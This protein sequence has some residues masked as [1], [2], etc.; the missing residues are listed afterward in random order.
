MKKMM[1]KLLVALLLI[2]LVAA[3][4]WFYLPKK[5]QR[6]HSISSAITVQATKV[7]Q[8]LQSPTLSMIGLLE[9]Q[10]SVMITPLIAGTIRAVK[11]SPG[12]RVKKGQILI[13]LNDDIYRAQLNADRVKLE[14][15]TTDYKRYKSLA[16]RGITSQQTL[17]SAFSDMRAQEAEMALTQSKVDQM[18]LHAPFTG[19]LGSSSVNVGAYAAIGQP[20]VRLVNTDKLLAK[21]SVPGEYF[22]KLKVGQSV[23]VKSDAY[24]KRAFKGKV[25]FVSPILDTD[26][27]TIAVHALVD[28]APSGDEPGHNALTSGMYVQIIQEVGSAKQVLVIPNTALVATISG[29]E[30]YQINNGRAT[31]KAIKIGHHVGNKVIVKQGLKLGDQIV[32]AGQEKLKDG[33][34]INVS[35]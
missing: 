25:S 2:I 33:S 17:D 35:P 29:V 28:N 24:P 21:Y 3:V 15:L 30:V 14:T 7:S 4:I 5:S 32:I 27:N 22:P 13:V 12:E 19:N 20:L 10:K 16:A 31:A 11:F 18:T 34:H 8:Q 26:T 23:S 1:P 6:A 9:A